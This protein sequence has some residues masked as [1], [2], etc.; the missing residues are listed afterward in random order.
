MPYT[1]KSQAREYLL[2][3][4]KQRASLIDVLVKRAKQLKGMPAAN[5]SKLHQS[6]F[7]DPT[8]NV[9]SSHV[10]AACQAIQPYFRD[11]QGQ[12]WGQPAPRTTHTML[13]QATSNTAD[14]PSWVWAS[15][16]CIDECSE[17]VLASSGA[18][19]GKL[20]CSVG[21]DSPV[22]SPGCSKLHL[23]VV[24]NGSREYDHDEAHTPG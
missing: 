16:T 14:Q 11:I 3:R 9:V 22:V 4:D 24:G 20:T 6:N 10:R 5:V 21:S 7:L 17:C 15:T 13:Q 19:Q 8:V 2:G 1:A 23:F 18:S 12:L